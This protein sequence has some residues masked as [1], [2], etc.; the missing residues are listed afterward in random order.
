MSSYKWYNWSW[1]DCDFLF[2]CFGIWIEFFLEDFNFLNKLIFS[3]WILE[4]G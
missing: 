2:L 3:L 1:D 4:N